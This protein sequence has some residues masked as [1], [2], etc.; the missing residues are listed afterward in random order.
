MV[1]A[2][3]APLAGGLM[4]RYGPRK[5]FPIGGALIGL[6]LIVCSTA[7]TI[8][9]FILYLVLSQG[10]VSHFWARLLIARSWPTGLSK[11]KAWAWVS[12]CL[13]LGAVSCLGCRPSGPFPDLAGGLRMS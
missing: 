3:G 1:Y 6:G 4:D 13:E 5:I 9:E 12:L 11:T 10:L 7:T 8:V 2:L